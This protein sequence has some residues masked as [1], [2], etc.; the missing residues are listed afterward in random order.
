METSQNLQQQVDKL[1]QAH[2]E[3]ARIIDD[4]IDCIHLQHDQIRKLSTRISELETCNAAA[5]EWS[6]WQ[7]AQL[8]AVEAAMIAG[9]V[10][11]PAAL[12]RAILNEVAAT[13]QRRAAA[14]D[15]HFTKDINHE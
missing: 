8:R 12:Y 10:A 3:N 15:G 7:H 1:T 14:R 6:T 2:W 9:N 5:L 4:L 13:D 11:E